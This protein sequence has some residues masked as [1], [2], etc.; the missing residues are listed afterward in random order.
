[1]LDEATG[2]L[3]VDAVQRLSHRLAIIIIA[4]R[5][6]SVRNCDVIPY[7]DNGRVICPGSCADQAD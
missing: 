6:N 1:V 3:D 5:L 2:A 7:I 4:H